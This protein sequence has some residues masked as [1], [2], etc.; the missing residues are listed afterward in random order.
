MS[1]SHHGMGTAALQKWS[2]MF[3]ALMECQSFP[4]RTGFGSGF[5][6]LGWVGGSSP[7]FSRDSPW[8]YQ[9]AWNGSERFQERFRTVRNGSY[10]VPS[11]TNL[12]LELGRQLQKREPAARF[13]EKAIRRPSKLSRKSRQEIS[14]WQSMLQM[15][16]KQACGLDVGRVG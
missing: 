4:T 3:P 13:Q 11:Y 15:Q 2:N 6:L 10:T 12:S 8:Q 16:E 7:I 1:T 14:D 5:C 9:R